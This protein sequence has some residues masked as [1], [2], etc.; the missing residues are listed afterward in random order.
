MFCASEKTRDDAETSCVAVG[1]H[2]IHVGGIAEELWMYETAVASGMVDDLWSGGIDVGSHDWAWAD[3]THFWSGVADGTPVNDAYA[4]FRKGEPNGSGVCVLVQTDHLWD[5]QDC[6]WT[7][8]FVCEAP[9]GSDDI[10]PYD[11]TMPPPLRC[12]CRTVGSSTDLFCDEEV[13]FDVARMVCRAAGMHLVRIEDATEDRAVRAVADE[14]GI[15]SYF[16]DGNDRA[17][18]G[19]WCW[20]DPAQTVFWIAAGL[21]GAGGGSSGGAGGAGGSAPASA[22]AGGTSGTAVDAYV[23]WAPD[24]P[25]DSGDCLRVTAGPAWDDTDCVA[26]RYVCERP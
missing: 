10:A 20:S 4:H 5:D 21:G 11:C 1:M 23:N 3:G 24:Q 6:A 7:R 19:R 13:G 17:A 26:Q 9:G 18:Q 25:N 2:L 15:E 22:G 8:A 14:L 12:T 16:A